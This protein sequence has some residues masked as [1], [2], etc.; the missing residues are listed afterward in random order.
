MPKQ[1]DRCDDDGYC[2]IDWGSPGGYSSAYWCVDNKWVI[3]NEAN[4]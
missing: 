1:G 4:E 3:E 2:E